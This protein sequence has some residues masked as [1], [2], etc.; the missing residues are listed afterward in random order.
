MGD[1]GLRD[2]VVIIFTGVFTVRLGGVRVG[3]KGVRILSRVVSRLQRTGR[4]KGTSL[5]LCSLG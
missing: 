4:G 1:P 5:Y 3:G 2:E